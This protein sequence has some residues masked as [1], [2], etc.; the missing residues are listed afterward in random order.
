MPLFTPDYAQEK[1]A[2]PGNHN[3]VIAGPA[4]NLEIVATMPDRNMPLQAIAV[5]CHPHPLHA[6]TMDNKVVCFIARTLNALG[7]GAVRFNFRGVGNSTGSYDHGHGETQDTLAVA[8]WVKQH[9]PHLP[10]WLSGFSFGAYIALRSASLV[11]VAQLITVSPP[12]NFFDFS[13]LL[14]P[15]CPLLIIQGTH[16]EIVPHDEVFAWAKT[17]KVSPAFVSMPGVDHF[18]HGRLNAL[19]SVLLT[20][21]AS[22]TDLAKQDFAPKRQHNYARR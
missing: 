6:G 15:I 10:L 13:T 3:G 12:V 19:Q 17:L 1:C 2:P 21:L 4:G 7:I 8:A 9:Y 22:A 18:F 11:P 14:T 5:V 16:D 20:S